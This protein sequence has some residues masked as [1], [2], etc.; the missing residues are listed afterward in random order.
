MARRE[1]AREDLM[2][3]AT[4]YAHRAEISFTG[5]PCPF[6]VGIREDGGFALYFG[7]DPVYHFDA[8]GRLRR[9]FVEGALFKSRGDTLARLERQRTASAVTLAR[10]DLNQH[11]LQQFLDSMQARLARLRE[12]IN[13]REIEILRQAPANG[14]FGERLAAALVLTADGLLSGPV[15]PRR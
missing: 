3:E 2:R 1:A 6:F 14:R 13:R 7:E 4:A 15:G 9:A 11:E 10:H 8:Q 5:E 12:A